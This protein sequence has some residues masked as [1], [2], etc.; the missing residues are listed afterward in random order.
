[1]LWVF[2]TKHGRENWMDL[3]QNARSCPASRA[4]LVNRVLVAG[5]TVR[6]A[7]EAQGLS[8]RSAYRWLRRYREGGEA[9]LRDRPSSPHRIP[10]RLG[11]D[12][13]KQL[14]ALRSERLSGA[15]IAGRLHI[16]RSTVSRW[17]RRVGLGRLPQLAAPEPIRRYEKSR[18]GELLHLDIKKLGRIQGVGHRITGQRQHRKQGPGWEFVQV[19]IDD[20]S[21]VAYA[22]ILEN[23]RTASALSFLQRAVAWFA[24]RHVTVERLLT[25][26]GSCYRANRFGELCHKLGLKHSK[27]RPYRPRT[28][29]KAER[30]IQTL[31]REWAYA[32]TFQNSADR[33][34]FLPRYLHFYNHH[35]AHT[36]LGARPPIS[37]LSLNNAVRINN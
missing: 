10:R 28:N 8:A 34:A 37:R 26:N 31:Q 11:K 17:L 5:W 20:A 32:F 3:H 12:E 23:E 7:A 6:K 25:D 13:L 27:T 4:L 19:A 21:R 30:F 1:M 14:L 22:E 24:R 35:R 36:A 15:E 9:S 16:P 2:K 29:G 33:S 18:P